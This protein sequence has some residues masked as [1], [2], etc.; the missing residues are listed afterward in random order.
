METFLFKTGGYDRF[1]KTKEKI[2]NYVC[3]VKN[4][5]SINFPVNS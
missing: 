2:S 5:Y 3:L 4:V 1:S